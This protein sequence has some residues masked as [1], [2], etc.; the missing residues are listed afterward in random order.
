MAAKVKW[1][2]WLSVL[3]TAFV[4]SVNGMFVHR[5]CNHVHPKDHEYRHILRTRPTTNR[6][7]NE[8]QKERKKG[9]KC[10]NNDVFYL[11]NDPRPFCKNAC[12]SVTMCGEV[13]VPEEHLEACHTCNA[14]G[15]ACAE[16]GPPPGRG[17]VGADFVFYVSALETA[18]C[19]RGLTVAYAA[20]CQ[21]EAALDRPVAATRTCCAGRHQARSRR[22]AGAVSR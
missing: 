21:Q 4:V 18:R 5:Q 6:G 9:R 13:P 17:I 10:E 20:H 8:R 19:H 2:H 11:G 16:G 7:K 3:L 1:K 12:E 14:T 22:A 15:Q